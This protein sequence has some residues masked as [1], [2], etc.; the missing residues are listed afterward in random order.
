M[1]SP[2]G[3]GCE[4]SNMRQAAIA[5][6]VNVKRRSDYPIQISL[7]PLENATQLMTEKLER[8]KLP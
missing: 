2:Q 6:M 7:D 4:R 8:C 3:D 5:K 1:L